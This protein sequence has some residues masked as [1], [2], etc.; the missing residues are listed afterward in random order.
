MKGSI[1][2]LLI[3][4]YTISDAQ[5][6]IQFG[7]GGNIGISVLQT[8]YTDSVP[9]GRDLPEDKESIFSTPNAVYG[10]YGTM[11]YKV[12]DLFTLNS[13]VSIA[14][15][16]YQYNIRNYL[17]QGDIKAI[18]NRI[19]LGFGVGLKSYTFSTE[20]EFPEVKKR[21]KKRG[22][23]RK[24]LEQLKRREK[25][26][27]TFIPYLFTEYEVGIKL[28]ENYNY[29]NIDDLEDLTSERRNF[30]HG[31]TIGFGLQ[32]K[33]IDLLFYFHSDFTDFIKNDE[34]NDYYFKD[35]GIKVAYQL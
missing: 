1:Y 3:L 6:R 23:R 30:L 20:K 22:K 7:V 4:L 2:L 17:D 27:P 5:E 26:K 19:E 35:L 10:I 13:N 34:I 32:Q 9:I 16:G 15:N 11:D 12:S 31:Y 24:K 29:A 8:K 25:R 28:A 18:Y 21:Y 33:S 14:G